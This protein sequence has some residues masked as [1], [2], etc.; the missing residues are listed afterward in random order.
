MKNIVC[1]G[2]SNTYGYDPRSAF[3]S[4]YPDGTY[5]VDILHIKTGCTFWNMGVCGREIPHTLY[6][7]QAACA[8]LAAREPSA[9]ALWIMLGTNDL[10]SGQQITAETVGLRM[11]VFLNSLLNNFPVH[12]LRLIIP[13]K[14]QQGTWTTTEVIEES[15]KLQPVFRSLADRLH[16]FLTQTESWNIPLAFDGVHFTEQGH[17][18]FAKNLLRDIPLL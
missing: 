9:D 13:V 14:M 17:K 1:F 16:V 6:Q 7:I 11:E 12:K 15:E 4:R 10:L 5:W 18:K 8:E 3:G 2:D